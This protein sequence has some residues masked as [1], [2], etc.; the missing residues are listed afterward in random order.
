VDEMMMPVIVS[1]KKFFFKQNKVLEASVDDVGLPAQLEAAGLVV[2]GIADLVVSNGVFN[3]C[4]DKRQAF[5]NVR[6]LNK[7]STYSD[8]V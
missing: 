6:I 8:F 4:V 3:L 5:L 7:Y 1:L 2:A